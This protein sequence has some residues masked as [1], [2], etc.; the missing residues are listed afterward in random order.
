MMK[1]IFPLLLC[2]CLI[3]SGCAPAAQSSSSTQ[4]SSSAPEEPESGAELPN[5]MVAYDTPDFT[6][7]A[8]FAITAL[9]QAE[10]MTLEGCWLI[11]G[12]VAQLDYRL[13]MDTELTFRVAVD[14]GEDISGVYKDDW[15]EDAVSDM[16][17][18][19]VRHRA[20]AGGPAL[21]TWQKDGYAFSMYFP[22]PRMGMAGGL[23]STF[24]QGVQLTP[25]QAPAAE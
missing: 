21:V 14:T 13:E 24:L 11:G 2:V 9:P 8:G 18:V 4:S 23:S 6:E 1:R 25:E 12:A 17:G 3:L 15:E 10:G 5:P 20:S 7:A 22:H 16:D 19:S